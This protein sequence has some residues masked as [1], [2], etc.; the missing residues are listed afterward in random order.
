[1]N[2]TAL[3]LVVACIAG[4]SSGSLFADRGKD[5]SGQGRWNYERDEYRPPKYKGGEY[6][7]EYRDGNCKVERQWER[8]GS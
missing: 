7:E 5:E 2:R 6:K 1:M 3:M 4:T 8:N